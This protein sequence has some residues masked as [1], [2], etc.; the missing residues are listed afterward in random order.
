MNNILGTFGSIRKNFEVVRRIGLITESPLKKEH[1][2]IIAFFF[3]F[4]Y[5]GKMKD[6]RSFV[7]GQPSNLKLEYSKISSKRRETI[8]MI[9]EKELQRIFDNLK[10]YSGDLKRIMDLIKPRLSDFT[11]NCIDDAFRCTTPADWL[12]I[13]YK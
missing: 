12:A 2:L 1:K 7:L 4:L 9:V 8:C 3:H 6:L 11:R 13:T 10:K 5:A